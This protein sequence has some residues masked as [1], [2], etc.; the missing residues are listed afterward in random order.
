MKQLSILMLPVIL[1][2]PQIVFTVLC[3]RRFGV[4]H[5]ESA[6]QNSLI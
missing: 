1:V 4:A 6:C 2:L 3:A 5:T